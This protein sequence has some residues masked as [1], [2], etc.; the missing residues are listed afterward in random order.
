MTDVS[1]RQ[2]VAGSP[3]GSWLRFLWWQM[4][5]IPCAAW[6]R[7]FYRLRVQGREHLPRTGPLL[8]VSNHESFL[9]PVIIGVACSPRPMYSM[10]RS[11]LFR[12]PLGP[13]IRSLNGIPV[14]R[15]TAD[16]ASIRRCIDVLGQGSALSIFPEGTRTEDGAMKPFRG[17]TMLLIKRAKPMV[18]PLAIAG[19]FESWPR[20]RKLPHLCG[21]LAV[22]FA[23]PVAA[24]TLIQMGEQAALESLRKTIQGMRDDMRTGMTT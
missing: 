20:K 1:L 3:R 8:I 22:R 2:V 7:L 9:D 17:G 19:S 10:A 18:M 12:F 24:E 23:P 5:R 13:V 15:G 11:T 6:F 16:L 21:R 4:L 14:E